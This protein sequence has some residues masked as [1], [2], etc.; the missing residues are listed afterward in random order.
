M[1]WRKRIRHSV[2]AWR[3]RF[4][5]YRLV[6]ALKAR[7]IFCSIH[8]QYRAPEKA[9]R[10]STAYH[11]VTG[12]ISVGHLR[13]LASGC[14]LD[15]HLWLLPEWAEDLDDATPANQCAFIVR[16]AS[17]LE[18]ESRRYAKEGYEKSDPKRAPNAADVPVSK[19]VYG[20]AI[21]LNVDWSKLDG[22]WG[23]KTNALIAQFGLCRPLKSESWHVELLR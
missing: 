7:G 2:S 20:L 10:H 3:L 13:E 9:H 4:R 19:H 18:P 15:G 12:K 11:I 23:P 1:K 6:R 22:D 17:E 21:D 16:N 14:D 8:H 5:V